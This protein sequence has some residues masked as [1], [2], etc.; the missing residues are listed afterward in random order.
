M[1]LWT[2][3]AEP[4]GTDRELLFR[5]ADGDTCVTW[6]EAAQESFRVAAALHARGV[7]PG[8][9]VACILTNSF[10]VGVTIPGIWF[11]GATL[12]S[13]PTIARG[14]NPGAYLMQLKR[15]CEE[16]ESDFLL[17]EQ[18]YASLIPDAANQDLPLFTYEALLGSSSGLSPS[19]PG[20]SDVAMIQYSSGST[21]QPKGCVLTTKAIARQLDALAEAVGIDGKHDRGVMWLPLSHDMGLFGGFL[22]AWTTGMA[23]VMSRPERFLTSP[24]SWFDECVNF[25]GTVTVGP[26]SGLATATRAAR[27]KP[28]TRPLSLRTCIIGGERVEAAM[29]RDVREVLGARGM[30]SN[31][32][33]PAYGL[34]EATLAV[35][36]TDTTSE[37]RM[38]TVDSQALMSG[39]VREPSDPRSIY[40]VVSCGRP[41]DGVDVTIDGDQDVGEICVRS[42]CLAEG[43][44]RDEERSRA[45]FVEGEL[46]T[47][48]WGF[49]DGGELF[50]VGRLDDMISVGGRNVHASAV[51]AAIERGTTVR[52][53]NCAIVDVPS[54]DRSALVMVAEPD[55]VDGIELREVART[56]RRI[57]ASE[58][59]LAL[60]EC[61]FV[62]RGTFPKT[63][64]GKA[65]R[66]RCRELVAQEATAEFE[67]IELS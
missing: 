59:G 57:A 44:F 24:R 47:G 3:L 14:E 34:A 9:R 12:V 55:R 17:I 65:Q 67:R 11:A 61:L 38:V 37:S 52:A 49:L 21:S 64:S 56:A 30:A 33:T 32:P 35:T 1:D 10:Q 13:L 19:P 27:R 48:D 45:A 62:P 6:G 66:F 16:V 36:M 4:T 51:E 31:V 41:L 25:D 22:L 63:P 28:P 58:G 26:G 60:D 42:P 2:R 43:Y 39:D 40:E 7:R 5:D 18:R 46:R 8:D 53:G 20:P 29:L 15:L 50:V 23:G 54:R